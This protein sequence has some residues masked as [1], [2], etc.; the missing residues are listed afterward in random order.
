MTN[1][2]YRYLNETPKYINSPSIFFSL[3]IFRLGFNAPE[4]V[5]DSA[6]TPI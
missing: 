4:A 6:V 5:A 1:A 3:G 2:K